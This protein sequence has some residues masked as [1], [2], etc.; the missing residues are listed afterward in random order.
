MFLAVAGCG[1]ADSAPADVATRAGAL[2][3]GTVSDGAHARLKGYLENVTE[4]DGWRYAAT[5]DAGHTM[6]TAKIIADP[7]ERQCLCHGVGAGAAQSLDVRILRQPRRPHARRR[8]QEAPMVLSPCANGTPNLY[9]ASN[10]RVDVGF[11]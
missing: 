7:A 2:R 6:D 9:S 8:R 3:P 10:T 4:A 11:H 1:A 5:D